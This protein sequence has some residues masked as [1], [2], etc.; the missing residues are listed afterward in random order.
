TLRFDKS[1]N[2]PWMDEYTLGYSRTFGSRGYVRTDL[3]TRKWGD[4]YV[5]R[6]TIQ[7]GKARDPNGT[8]F[9]QGVIENSSDGL[10]RNYRA[11]QL[12]GSYRAGNALTVGGN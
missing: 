12:Q 10:S 8:L 9:D 1:L 3:V 5:V 7:T 2:A 6:R 11:L 4:F